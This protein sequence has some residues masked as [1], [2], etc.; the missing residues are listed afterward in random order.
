MNIESIYLQIKELNKKFQSGSESSNEFAKKESELKAILGEL[1]SIR[2]VIGKEIRQVD[3]SAHESQ[4]VVFHTKEPG[5]NP[6][7]IVNVTE[8]N[9]DAVSSRISRDSVFVNNL[10]SEIVKLK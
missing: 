10:V 7:Q 5:G 4:V 3:S 6:V 2:K 8:E 9:V 1:D